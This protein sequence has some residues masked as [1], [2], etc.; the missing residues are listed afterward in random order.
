MSSNPSSRH[1]QR[2]SFER[3]FET[4]IL[5][6]ARYYFPTL[7]SNTFPDLFKLRLYQVGLICKYKAKNIRNILITLFHLKHYLP[8][9]SACLIFQISKS[10][11]NEIV[12]RTISWI[13]SEFEH[14]VISMNGREENFVPE[15]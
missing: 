11:Y 2:R 12:N 10:W 7:R 8:A 5:D 6:T 9:R 3:D 4:M 15:F 13:V 14:E 1:H